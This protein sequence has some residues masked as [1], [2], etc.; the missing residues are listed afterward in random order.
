M[1]ILTLCTCNDFGEFLISVKETFDK[2]LNLKQTTKCNELT[3]LHYCFVGL[4][5]NTL[6]LL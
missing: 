3:V 4:V 1:E 5:S 2:G 6:I